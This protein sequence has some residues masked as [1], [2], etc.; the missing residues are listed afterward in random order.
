M[1][2]SSSELRSSLSVFS[3]LLVATDSCFSFS[4][5]PKRTFFVDDVFVI[6]YDTSFELYWTGW[7]EKDE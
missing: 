5:T 6:R 2:G 4:L 1:I 7:I 3:S